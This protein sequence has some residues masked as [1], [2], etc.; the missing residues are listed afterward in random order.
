MRL[1][2]SQNMSESLK[3][4]KTNDFDFDAP[5]KFLFRSERFQK[6]GT[7]ETLAETAYLMLPSGKRLHNYGKS[8]FSMGKSTISMA[9]FNSKLLQIT[10]G[11]HW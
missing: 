10:R 7:R 11:Y 9:I 5:L 3:P 8:P 1:E 6:R 4:S 2:N